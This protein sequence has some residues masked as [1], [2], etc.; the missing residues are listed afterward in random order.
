[1]FYNIQKKILASKERYY[2]RIVFTQSVDTNK[3]ME[4]CLL[5][6]HKNNL[7]QF[8]GSKTL[9]IGVIGDSLLLY[10]YTEVHKE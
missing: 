6:Q 4:H 5:E 9:R 7:A 2:I 8:T 3:F 1:M 10:P